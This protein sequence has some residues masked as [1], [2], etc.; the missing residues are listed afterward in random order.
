MRN[1]AAVRLSEIDLKRKKKDDAIAV[2]QELRKLALAL[3]SGNLYK[4]AL[5][6]QIQIDP[7]IDPFKNMEQLAP[8]TA[9]APD[10][11]AAEWID[12]QPTKRA[13]LRR[14]AALLDY[15]APWRG[16]CRST[17]P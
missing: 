12:S 11:T 5:R 3:P 8:S 9:T 2:T 17:L 6:R 1:G 16:P 10:L 4:L 7:A 15:R 13:D 14:Q